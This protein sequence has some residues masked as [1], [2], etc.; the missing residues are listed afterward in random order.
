V[1]RVRCREHGGWVREEDAVVMG[2][3]ETGSGVTIPAYA[4]DACV[5]EKGL[6]PPRR[7]VGRA[8]APPV[9]PSGF[10]R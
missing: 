2:A 6:V 10:R 7:F 5:R 1:S 8:Y 4:C 3:T 9:P